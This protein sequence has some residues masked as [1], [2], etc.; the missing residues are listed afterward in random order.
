MCGAAGMLSCRVLGLLYSLDVA[1]NVGLWGCWVV[2]LQG[3]WALEV[4]GFR[5]WRL[6]ARLLVCRATELHVWM[7]VCQHSS[8]WDCWN[9]EL[10]DCEAAGWWEHGNAGLEGC[11]RC[12]R[13][14]CR[15]AGLRR[16]GAAGLKVGGRCG[17]A[18]LL[19]CL[20]SGGG[21]ELQGWLRGGGR[22]LLSVP[23]R[24]GVALGATERR[25]DRAELAGGRRVPAWPPRE[26]LPNCIPAQSRDEGPGARRSPGTAPVPL[27]VRGACGSVR[28][29]GVA[30]R[31]AAPSLCSGSGRFPARL[32]L[33][34]AVAAA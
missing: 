20:R 28:L 17:G 13:M 14:G 12:P 8:L 11:G 15:A 5:D 34:L 19:G 22:P 23:P 29:G 27:A 31:R 26:H 16:C 21:A 32:A 18:E 2:G 3:C 4:L 30:G 6:D 25:R 1:L 33:V 24:P 9:T 7:R 10:G